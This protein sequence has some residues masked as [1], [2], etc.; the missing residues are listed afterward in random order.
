ML[1]LRGMRRNIKRNEV[2]D[3]LV[4]TCKVYEIVGKY[5]HLVFV[6]K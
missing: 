3:I 4:Y 6:V 1:K 5:S 2:E